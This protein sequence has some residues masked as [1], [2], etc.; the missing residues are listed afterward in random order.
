MLETVPIEL[1]ELLG[2]LVPEGV[3][4]EVLVGEGETDPS[5]DPF[6]VKELIADR[7]EEG[8]EEGMALDVDVLVKLREALGLAVEEGLRVLE[9][10]SVELRVHLELA[11]G[12][13]VCVPAAD[14]VAVN[15]L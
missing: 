8:E 10:L 14:R 13:G 2:E 6:A 7:V 5:V 3:G 1:L 15:V 9:G 4:L 11:D 12:P